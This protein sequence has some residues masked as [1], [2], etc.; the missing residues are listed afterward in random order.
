MRICAR[1]RILISQW[2]TLPEWEKAQWIQFEMSRTRRLRDLMNNLRT[3]KGEI[4]QE[5][6]LPIALALMG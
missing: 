6:Y 1:Q 5:V 2:L 3:D 4:Y